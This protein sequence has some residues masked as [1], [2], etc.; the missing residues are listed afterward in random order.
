MS[1][2][3]RVTQLIGRRMSPVVASPIDLGPSNDQL[4]QMLAR[5][6]DRKD[7]L[8][9]LLAAT[10]DP[11]A[12]L[13]GL[14]NQSLF[15]ILSSS[16][17]DN[18]R[19][20]FESKRM[21]V[22]RQVHQVYALRGTGS[23]IIEI[24]L[25]FCIGD[26][27]KPTAADSKN[28]EL[29]TSLDEI[30]NDP[31]NRLSSRGEAMARSLFLEGERFMPATLS[32]IDGHLEL[33]YMG[34]EVVKGVR[35]DPLGRDVFLDVLPTTPGGS[36]RTY[37]VLDCVNENVTIEVLPAAGGNDGNAPQY[38]ITEK[39]VG[40]NASTSLTSVEVHGLAFAWFENRPEGAK[41]GRSELLNILDYVDIH[42]EL[43]WT[44]LEISKL[45][46]LFILDISAEGISTAE[47][48]RKKIEELG[49]ST[50]PDRPKVICHNDKVQVQLL[51][52][53]IAKTASEKLEQI[54]ALNIYGAKGMPEHWRGSGSDTNL[55]T[56][57]AQ[58][59]VP[60][61]RMRRKQF[62]LLERFHR[63]VEVSIELRKRAGSLTVANVDFQMAHT[64]VGGKD[65][66]RGATVLKDVVFAMS[67]ATTDQLLSRE[68]ANAVI[69]QTIR[70]VGFELEQEDA[71]LPEQDPNA[72]LDKVRK[73][74]DQTDPGNLDP[75]GEE[76]GARGAA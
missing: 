29:Q 59:L 72:D 19:D 4:K 64:E 69:V 39:I 44:D 28:T 33:G 56:A 41:R 75:A 17:D 18:A 51:Q 3:D 21:E 22:L 65:K 48:A 14:H 54:V 47:D 40:A 52:G 68:A 62:R 50:P 45:L 10:G 1:L 12:K 24:M 25:D 43:L 36:D 16:A 76:R 5:A 49:L 58:E 7:T 60:M 26:G 61:K 73:L 20:F 30:W 53:S 8:E 6:L 32:A 57:Q 63:L 37:Y 67:Q 38:R 27:F 70:E 71:A 15:R 23:N 11:D 42:D 31:R 2:M 46:R 34:P 55:A 74:L 9:S 66:S 35:Q 13:P